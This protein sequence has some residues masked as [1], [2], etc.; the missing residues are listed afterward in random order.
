MASI[1]VCLAPLEGLEFFG[2]TLDMAVTRGIHPCKN[3]S[4]APDL[5]AHG[6]RMGSDERLRP[7]VRLYSC[8]MT[9]CPAKSWRDFD[10]RRRLWSIVITVLNRIR[11]FLDNLEVVFATRHFAASSRFRLRD[12]HEFHL[13]PISKHLVVVN[14]LHGWMSD[15]QPGQIHGMAM[16]DSIHCLQK[17]LC[18]FASQLKSQ[19]G[20]AAKK[21]SQKLGLELP[22]CWPHLRYI[23][24]SFTLASEK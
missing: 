12:A 19:C 6:K 20:H 10:T 11:N 8:H 5:Q 18:S 16:V 9:Y 23:A 15:E 2:H 7:F 21:K 1:F 3:C 24:N 13:N 4:Q 22:A 14:R 17:D